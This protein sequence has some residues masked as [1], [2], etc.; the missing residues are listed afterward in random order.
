MTGQVR[1][2]VFPLHDVSRML[3][4]TIADLIARA[5]AGFLNCRDMYKLRLSQGC[6]ARKTI[7]PL[8]FRG[9]RASF[10]SGG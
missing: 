1:G 3:S 5:S 7:W 9:R 10:R 6:M 4:R 8:S 2:D